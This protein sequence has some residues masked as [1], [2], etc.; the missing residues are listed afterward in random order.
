[1]D[2]EDNDIGGWSGDDGGNALGYQTKIPQTTAAAAAEDLL[3][4]FPPRL[5]YYSQ[6]DYY[7][8]EVD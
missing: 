7:Y 6:F 2:K 1:M 8:D 4:S 5:L 3:Q